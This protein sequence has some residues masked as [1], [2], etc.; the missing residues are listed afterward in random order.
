MPSLQTQRT[1]WQHG[2]AY[3][4]CLFVRVGCRKVQHG[5]LLHTVTTPREYAG[6][7]PH[8]GSEE[9]LFVLDRPIR[10]F[11]VV[12]ACNGIREAVALRVSAIR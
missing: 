3:R 5:L 2:R 9:S 11:G 10:C 6:A 7:V 8:G 1:Q 4:D 12:G